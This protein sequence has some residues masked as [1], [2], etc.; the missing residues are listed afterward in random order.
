MAVQGETVSH[1]YVLA[2]RKFIDFMPLFRHGMWFSFSVKQF[3][4][5]EFG[6]WECATYSCL[7]SSALLQTFGKLS[8]LQGTELSVVV[9]ICLLE[10][11]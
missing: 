1:Y 4:S 7:S 10:S 8:S 3:S 2:I 9:V 11:F 6:M 5:A